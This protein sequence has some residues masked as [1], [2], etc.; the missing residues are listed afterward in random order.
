MS[1]IS[2]FRRCSSSVIGKLKNGQN[3]NA[4]GAAGVRTITSQEVIDR[5]KKVVA[6]T[7]DTLPVV[8]SRGEGV[9]IWDVEGR[10]YLDFFA[11]YATLNQGHCHPRILKVLRDQAGILHHTSRAIY[12]DRLYQISE[13]LTS[14]FKYDQL[15]LTN[16][17]AEGVEG[18]VKLSRK[19]GY[20]RKQIPENMGVILFAEGN[21]AGRTLMATSA[22]TDPIAFTGFGPFLP[23]V[24]HVPYNNL[25]KLEE[26]LAANPNVCAYVVEPIQGE[27]GAVTPDPGYLKGVRDLCTKYNV[28]WVADEVQAGLGRTGKLAAVHHENVQPD[29]LVLGKALSGGFYPVS[30]I[31]ANNDVMDCFTPGTHGSTYG[32]SPLACAVALEGVKVIIE[33][34]LTE[35]AAKMGDIF[36]SEISNRVH[37][38][39]LKRVQGKGLLKAIVLNSELLNPK[40]ITKLLKENGLVTKH[41]RQE[42]IRIS[43]ALTITEG[44]LRAGIDIIVDTINNAPLKR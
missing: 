34:K 44:E 29:I 26:K 9:Y 23:G 3:F 30:G 36:S 21:F 22:S 11:G 35:N 32:G 14:L 27:A 24:D 16:S 17:G 5:E 38:D 31:L 8:I 20:E 1:P 41:I 37:K 4:S 7:Y 10:R 2:A 18:A 19:W 43:P 12:H 25:Q 39:R 40:K 13:Y 42:I 28:L 33:E 15:F 6:K